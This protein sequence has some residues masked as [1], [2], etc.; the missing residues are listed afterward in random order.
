MGWDTEESGSIQTDRLGPFIF[1]LT[2]VLPGFETVYSFLSSI[3]INVWSF[4]FTPPY[5]FMAWWL[6]MHMEHV[7]SIYVTTLPIALDLF[8]SVCLIRH[9][10]DPSSR[11]P[12]LCT[13]FR[14]IETSTVRNEIILHE[15]PPCLMCYN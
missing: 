12:S 2:L 14:C 11:Y 4:S 13:D 10:G 1:F 7:A 9:K 15:W 6:I 8:R 3:E 5:V